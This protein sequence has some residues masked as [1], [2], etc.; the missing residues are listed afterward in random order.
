MRGFGDSRLEM[1]NIVDLGQC[2]VHPECC[3][4]GALGGAIDAAGVDSSGSCSNG[5]IFHPADPSPAAASPTATTLVYGASSA[6][7]V[8]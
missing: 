8:P 4:T 3:Q 7:R 6:T 5:I 1:G 2:A